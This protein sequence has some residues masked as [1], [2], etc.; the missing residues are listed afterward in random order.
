MPGMPQHMH[1]PDILARLDDFVNT[2]PD[3]ARI[4]LAELQSNPTR[5]LEE[6]S[7]DPRF[8]LLQR[9]SL[10]P[11]EVAAIEAKLL[12]FLK[13]EGVIIDSGGASFVDEQRHMRRDW[14]TP[15]P[16]ATPVG[17]DGWWPEQPAPVE[18]TIRQGTIDA[19]S[20][21]FARTGRR[22]DSYWVCAG[23]AD[24]PDR[25]LIQCFVTWND[26]QVTFIILTPEHPYGNA[27]G[28]S[29]MMAAQQSSSAPKR[30]SGHAKQAAR[31]IVVVKPGATGKLAVTPYDLSRG[32]SG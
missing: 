30:R 6:I 12:V 16:A 10:R 18:D 15:R 25:V 14:Y 27:G 4:Y 32:R 17:V 5:P 29:N 31:G 24:G 2:D 13:Q 8:K 22:L 21:V 7:G 28:M 23:A 9:R 20:Q 1:K 11:E 3:T 26:Q 19:L